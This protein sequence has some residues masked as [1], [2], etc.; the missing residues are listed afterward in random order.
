MVAISGCVAIL[1]ILLTA[2]PVLAQDA[3]AERGQRGA[4]ARDAPSGGGFGGPSSVGEELKPGDGLTDPQF[5]SRFIKEGLTPWIDFKAGL[6]ENYNLNIGLD[7]QALSQFSTSDLGEGNAAGGIF[8]AFGSWTPIGHDSGNTGTLTFKVETRHAYTD[9]APQDLGFDSGALSVTGAQFSDIGWALTNLYWTQRLADGEAVL[10]FGQ[11]DVTDYIDVYGMINPLTSFQNLAFLTNPS[12]APPSSGLGVVGGVWL[13]DHLYLTA[14]LADAN[15]DP[16][17][18]DFELF[19]DFETFKH[20][21][22][23][24][25]ASRERRYFDK[26]H[27]TFWHQDERDDAGVPEDHGVAGSVA[28]FFD[29]K[30]MPFLRAGIADGDAALYKATVSAGLGY[31]SRQTDLAGIG[32]N[33]SQPGDSS[34]DDQFTAEV[35]YRFQ[36]SESFA[37]TPSIQLIANPALDPDE[38]LVAIFGMRARIGF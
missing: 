3:E 4:V 2:L 32:L 35:F 36:A 18:P 6:S 29:N 14:G 20:A 38:D 5:R 24:W 12:I 34:L 28:W 19:D 16:T 10:Q 27:L 1:C 22:I 13:S 25:V 15:G 37:I 7:Y 26:I 33:W 11:V 31:Y 30:W 9:V 8:R 23:G 17:D 21:E